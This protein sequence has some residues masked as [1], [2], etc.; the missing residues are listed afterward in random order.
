MLR[1][2]PKRL[3]RKAISKLGL[4][5]LEPRTFEYGK[6]KGWIAARIAVAEALTM[7]DFL[8]PAAPPL[9]TFPALA[10]SPAST[11]SPTSIAS[12]AP[13][14]PTA[15]TSSTAPTSTSAFPDSS[16]PATPKTHMTSPA[17][18]ASPAPFAPAAAETTT[19][20]PMAAKVP[21]T[22]VIITT[23]PSAPSPAAR[24]GTIRAGPS[25]RLGIIRVEPPRGP[26]V[27]PHRFVQPKHRQES[28][29]PNRQ[30]PGQ[31]H[32][33]QPTSPFNQKPSPPPSHQD[34]G[35][36]PQQPDVP[37]CHY[38]S[39][40]HQLPKGVDLRTDLED[41]VVSI[42]IRD[43]LVLGRAAQEIPMAPAARGDRTMRDYARAGCPVLSTPLPP[44]SPSQ[45]R[46]N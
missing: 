22:T 21:S 24:Q 40:Q 4:N 29:L 6:H 31:Q 46:S 2:L 32:R 34:P 35:Q 3:W 13:L 43:R 16:T 25:V 39:G 5:P 23:L 18:L 28:A 20:I 9:T 19:T 33:P 1:A 11:A 7:F 12:P 15:S 17:A 8:T 26:P 30:V 44:P 27:R 38:C 14:A 10:I 41:G 36:P 37:P 42:N 45:A